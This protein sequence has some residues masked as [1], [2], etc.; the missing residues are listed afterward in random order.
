MLTWLTGSASQPPICLQ[1][2]SSKTFIVLTVASAVFTDIFT[3]GIVVPVL[4]FAL[5]ERAGI[6]PDQVQS[7][8]SILLAVYGAA[9]LAA[10][11]VC[12]LLADKSDSR[13]LPLI[14]GLIALGGATVMLC[15][16]T[17]IAVLAAGRAL[18]GLSAAVV[19]VVGLALLVDTVGSHEIGQAMGYVGMAM[20]LG[21]LLAPLLSGV[22]YDAADYYSVYYM[23]FG[24]IVVDIFLRLAIVERK[25]AVRWLPE[26]G[27]T[28]EEKRD[29]M[30][31]IPGEPKQFGPI[32]G[33]S[34]N[35]FGNPST[36]DIEMSSDVGRSK[37]H[38]VTEPADGI[39][40]DVTTPSKAGRSWGDRMPP[41]LWLLSSRRLLSA[42]WAVLIQ[43]SLLTA[44]DSVLPLY[45]RDTFGWNSVGA[46]LVFLPIVITSFFGPLIG[47]A[48]D[49]YG[50]R[51][52]ATAGF[53]M[54]TPLL[55]LL[56]L[57]DHNSLKQ[58]VLLCALLALIGIA[59]ALQLTPVMAEI[60]YTVVAKEQKQ[61]PGFFG[62]NGAY[63]QAY[64]LFNMGFAAGSLV[65]PLVAGMVVQAHGWGLATLILGILSIVTAV[66]V[67]IWTGGSIRKKRGSDR[68][69]FV[70]PPRS[71][72]LL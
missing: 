50:P 2:R 34:G 10:S 53:V 17:S 6:S 51:W 20:S 62:K 66:P 14:L 43:A 26:D 38:D 21:I 24:L 9:L 19:W 8:V 28:E 5:E 55:I 45:V 72:T 64:G 3:Y 7:W 60:T 63:A 13:R 30:I 16:G 4:P 71:T 35:R 44:F 61:A 15:V 70:D 47:W 22:V 18:Q 36:D 56:R 27:K 46:G 37:E 41:V 69:A 29:S 68:E 57:V 42:L 59:L 40:P 48:S 49:K 23:A 32:E 67:V 54:A 1:F 31:G 11:P 33:H 65:G 12:G 52:F 39:A 58:K 25:V